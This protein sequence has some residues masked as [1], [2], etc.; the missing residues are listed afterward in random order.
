MSLKSCSKA[1]LVSVTA[2]GLVASWCL[3]IARAEPPI[4]QA[5]PGPADA[6]ERR[7]SSAETLIRATQDSQT[8]DIIVTASLRDLPGLQLQPGQSLRGEGP[9]VALRFVGP[10]GVRLSSDNRVSDLRLEVP[11]GGRAVCNDATVP[12]LGRLELAGLVTVG[13]VQIVVRD[14]VRGGH[15]EVRGLDIVA[16]DA[17]GEAD[18][19]RG[20]GVEVLQGAFTL[21]N[22]RPDDVAVSADLT[23]LS[24]G[25][26]DQPVVGSGVFVSGAGERGGRVVVSRL[27]TAALYSDGK[28][29]AGTADRITGGMFV[30]MRA[31]VDAVHVRGP[32]VT[33]GVNDM[34]LDNWGV[35]DRWVV[36]EKVTTRGASGIG[37]VN[38]GTIDDLRLHAPVETFGSGARGFNVYD[39]TIRSAEFDR[40]VTHADGAVG[41][42]LSRPVGRLAV[43]RGIETFGG[44]GP[45]LVKG[46]V[47]SLPAVALS[48]KPGGEVRTLEIAGGLRTNG[49]GIPPLEQGGFV[50]SM[51]IT[52]GTVAAGNP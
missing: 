40:I 16:A 39:G 18:R 5:E 51:K 42:Q 22:D 14:Q 9:R 3:L 13:R 20:Y 26:A 8:R 31:D 46:V 38:F 52:E 32:V 24:V 7:V 4:I 49:K 21:W 37:F 41:A 19:P 43:R 28:I 2:A 48:I 27:E 47:Q 45:S 25:R 1:G 10:D 35:V 29:A 12:G 11:P 15:I 33:Y 30:G 34:A 17:R 44:T 6:S 36:D 23:G 50:D